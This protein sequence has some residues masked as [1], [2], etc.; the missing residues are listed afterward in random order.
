MNPTDGHAEQRGVQDV[1]VV[2]L[3]EGALFLMS[4]QAFR[5][6]RLP[7][8]PRQLREGSP[9]MERAGGPTPTRSP[10]E[11]KCGRLHG[12]E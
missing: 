9:D 3:H 11:P 8:R 10:R 4:L 7:H 2:V 6:A 1:G 12:Y 5:P